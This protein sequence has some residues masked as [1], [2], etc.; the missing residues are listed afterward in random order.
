MRAQSDPALAPM[1]RDVPLV[2]KVKEL[3]QPQ[4]GIIVKS[5]EPARGDSVRPGMTPANKLA[6]LFGTPRIQGGQRR[7]VLE[8]VKQR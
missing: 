7:E 3:A 1:G 4:D 5:L 8:V 6:Q 2:G